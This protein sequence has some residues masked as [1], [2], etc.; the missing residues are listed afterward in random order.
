MIENNNQKKIGYDWK[1]TIGD[2][3]AYSNFK[4][5]VEVKTQNKSI[6]VEKHEHEHKE[7]E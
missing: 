6:G 4:N 7:R 2:T 3:E 5:P 1:K